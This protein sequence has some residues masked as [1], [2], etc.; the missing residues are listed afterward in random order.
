MRLKMAAA[1]ALLATVASC[2][3]EAA[4]SP[5]L[6]SSVGASPSVPSPTGSEPSIVSN[7]TASPSGIPTTV[8]PL[9]TLPPGDWTGIHWT[10]F[11]TTADVWLGSPS[12]GSTS[13]GVSVDYWSVFGW[14][15]GYLAFA[16]AATTSNGKN[17][18]VVETKHS[19]DGL[20][21]ENG[22]SFVPPPQAGLTGLDASEVDGLLSGP[23]GLLAYTWAGCNCG[24]VPR[25]YPLAV[26]PDGVNWRSVTGDVVGEWLDAGPS[27][28]I[29]PH[30]KD[31]QTSVDGVSWTRFSLTGA[32]RAEIDEINSAT[33]FPGG[34]AIT[35]EKHGPASGGCSDLPES[36]NPTIWL[37]RD[38]THWEK[39]NPPG[40][41]DKGDASLWVC[42]I[43]ELLVAEEIFADQT[44]EWTSV[45][46]KTWKRVPLNEGMNQFACLG[47][48]QND[49][50][51]SNDF[52]MGSHYLR[53]MLDGQS[54][55]EVLGP[56]LL[57]RPLTQ[58]GEAP[59]VQLLGTGILG[60]RGL[61]VPDVDVDLNGDLWIGTLVAG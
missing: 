50:D 17:S 25:V 35:G 27:G 8:T 49:P 55:I 61:V 6:G 3:G 5:S 37:S 18:A 43:G 58:T 54:G 34:Y 44:R 60:P 12:V 23:S 52:I 21:W 26:S 59:N 20:T 57:Y 22:S 24:C 38:G 46:G 36:L 51:N 56:D 13:D 47:D 53:W 28:Y 4:P 29:A 1:I 33:S 10:H 16:I 40:V 30:G 39:H 9:P 32:A 45:D 11:K 7:S 14:T 42:T 41:A 15:E 19:A 48:A 31:V 2:T